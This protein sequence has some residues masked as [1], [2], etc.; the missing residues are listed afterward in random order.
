M[1]K[2]VWLLCACMAM[3][4][5]FAVAG[6]AA[7]AKEADTSV[8]HL[9]QTVRAQGIQQTIAQGTA[10]LDD[11]QILLEENFDG[12]LSWP[13]GWSEEILHGYGVEWSLSNATHN[14][15]NFA[16]TAPYAWIDPGEDG[17][18]GG[19]YDAV[20]KTPVIQ[21]GSSVDFRLTMDYI[22]KGTGAFTVEVASNGSDEW[23]VAHSPEVS[24]YSDS[25][26]RH[27]D[28]AIGSALAEGATEFQVRFRYVGGSSLYT[29]IDNVKIV[30]CD[31][32]VT[33]PAVELVSTV[34][35][36]M[37]AGED[38]S[39]EISATDNVGVETATVF[40]GKWTE[41][42]GFTAVSNHPMIAGEENHYVVNTPVNGFV[43]GEK[44]AF[45]IEVADAAGN[46][47][48]LPEAVNEFYLTTV[49]DR[50]VQPYYLEEVGYEWVDISDQPDI[51]NNDDEVVQVNLVDYGFESFSWYG[52]DYSTIHVSSNGWISFVEP[53]NAHY[54]PQE[55]FPSTESP[56]GGIYVMHT[57]MKPNN[58][59]GAVRVKAVDGKLVISYDE[60]EIVG[61]TADNNTNV[62]IV[63][64]MDTDQVRLNYKNAT[65][66]DNP[67][68]TKVHMIAFEDHTGTYGDLLYYG[69]TF[70][71]PADESSY[72]ITRSYFNINGVA[73]NA[74]TNATLANANV[75][76]EM[77]QDGT[78]FA[79]YAATTSASDGVFVFDCAPLIEGAAYRLVG[80]LSG[81]LE[82]MMPFEAHLGHGIT[83]DVV[84][85]INPELVE[86]DLHGVV[87]DRDAA[88]GTTV[89]GIN[90]RIV[91]TDETVATNA[92][93]AFT[94]GNRGTGT[95]TLEVNAG[96]ANGTY[97]D[98]QASYELTEGGAQAE[99]YVNEIMA[100][101]AL[102][103]EA[104]EG[105]AT[106]RFTAPV[107]EL[108]EEDLAARVGEL[109]GLLNEINLGTRNF[110]NVDYLRSELASC[111]AALAG[112]AS[113]DELDEVSDFVGYRVMVDGNILNS[114]YSGSPIV[115]GGLENA[116]YH[117]FK[118][119]ADY[120]YGNDHL[121]FTEEVTARPMADN[122][123][124]TEKDY[125][126]IEIRTN[127]LATPCGFMVNDSAMDMF[128]FANGNSF[129]LLGRE[130]TQLQ[131]AASGVLVFVN[132]GGFVS[133][134]VDISIPDERNPNGLIAP[135]WR[136]YDVRE[137]AERDA[138]YYYDT[139]NNLFVVTWYV[140]ECYEYPARMFEFQAVLDLANNGI[141]F[142][143]KHTDADEW[144]TASSTQI[145]IEGYLGQEGYAFD[146]AIH[147][148]MSLRV[149]APAN[150]YGV[151]NG[152]IVDCADNGVA[153]VT[154]KK[155]EGMSETELAV[156]D[157]NG[158][159]SIRHEMGTINAR[160]EKEG[161]IAKEIEIIF[162][163]NETTELGN[164]TLEKPE[165]SLSAT[166]VEMTYDISGEDAATTTFTIG[167]TGC[168]TMD[169]SIDFAVQEQSI[170]GDDEGVRGPVAGELDSF[171]DP[172]L[173]FD[174]FALSGCQTLYG[175][176]RT[177]HSFVVNS[178]RAPY[179]LF[180]FNETGRQLIGTHQFPCA[181]T[182]DM[183]YDPHTGY[184]YS[185][186]E[187]GVLYRFN[188][189]LSEI[190][191]IA[192]IG[193]NSV[194]CAYDWDHKLIY[195]FVPNEEFFVYDLIAGNKRT[196]AMPENTECKL[197]A[198]AYVPTDSE[199]WTVWGFFDYLTPI[200]EDP[201]MVH[202]YNPSTDTWDCEGGLVMA[203]IYMAGGF[204][205]TTHMAEDRLDMVF[206]NQAGTEGRFVE[207]YE[208]YE[209]DLRGN[210]LTISPS[211]GDV[212][213]GAEQTVTVTVDAS[214][215]PEFVYENG[216]VARVLLTISGEYIED[217]NVLLQIN[218]ED[219]GVEDEMA[220]VP[221]AYALHQNFPN[222]FN[223]STEIKFDLV[224]NQHVKVSVFNMLG[225]EVAKVVD[226]PM[227]AGFHTV[228]F[229][230]SKLASGVY[231]YRIDAGDFHAMKK[232][233]LV[234]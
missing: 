204:S 78:N 130:Y 168:G 46:I 124:I 48:R 230:G 5:A 152:T 184:I 111:E 206:L 11:E 63:L 209:Y 76:L 15:H 117:T 139:E 202:R 223:P 10:E 171:G 32:E 122:Y 88:E 27:F 79:E 95:Y 104:G 188:S 60:V 126:W 54:R 26:T 116:V 40:T 153:D 89:S 35:P 83:Y 68:E 137:R 167:N 115:I 67:D 2:R 134:P 114:V 234:K 93:G 214:D 90:V 231:F 154:I 192:R 66:P 3:L 20:M 50:T 190:D 150:V 31:S 119:A 141:D 148:A 129:E 193:V 84:F 149:I 163:D 200:S 145:G 9:L 94:F 197:Y 4:V 24:S 8:P 58:G 6:Y 219:S 147:D 98:S 28:G 38:F 86:A 142:N 207:V 176:A 59:D 105:A 82:S 106:L 13:E 71:V 61:V 164:V 162:G 99:L 132:A 138:Y 136:F 77:A 225:Q 65:F 140:K 178:W 183:S 181:I 213:A 121:L 72:L 12:D 156:T 34:K 14:Y 75:V 133:A 45:Y 16:D 232:M 53:S 201:A 170:N 203:S 191:E 91:E 57:D 125:E 49:F 23:V 56:N 217:T 51:N 135:L 87:Y 205:T 47:A 166:S 216:D 186:S 97:H 29:A 39:A 25:E 229:D 62:Q 55:T 69:D 160:I 92:E 21:V 30:G 107:N 187:E 157:E 33:P 100:P 169:Y 227:Q 221:T 233:V 208:G 165:I 218:V 175:V 101:T 108:P 210:W 196:L 118:V 185:I 198:L 52:V 42:T 70:A 173:E 7:S 113:T 110:D 44:L 212:E 224:N 220:A 80:N 144:R 127:G 158:A 74:T 41:S 103:A 172:L 182:N 211:F 19:Q 226:A 37:Y 128:D 112:M 81:Y 73:K 18:Y 123:V 143:Y 43:G 159:F 64:D 151:V 189:D 146:G 1:L 36:Y 228:S 194:A 17:T 199:G 215:A 155:I 161:Y 131:I 180:E 102:A 96:I 179:S 222:P 120:G 22:F 85:S 177:E 109:R 174:A 195:G